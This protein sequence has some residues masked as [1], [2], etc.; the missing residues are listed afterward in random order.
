MN[1][2]PL[3]LR[4]LVDVVVLIAAFIMMDAPSAET[5]IQPYAGRGA[6][7]HASASAPM[8][9]PWPIALSASGAV[10]YG[11]ESSVYRYDPRTKSIS[12]VAGVGPDGPTIDGL[13][14]AK[15]QLGRASSLAVAPDGTLYIADYERNAIL[16]VDTHGIISVFAGTPGVAGDGGDNGP[17][18]MARFN[19]PVYIATDAAG[20]L[21]VADYFN[22][23][24]R[25]IQHGII[26]TVAGTEGSYPLAVTVDAHGSLYYVDDS[27]SAYGD[28]ILYRLPPGGAPT[29][30]TPGGLHTFGWLEGLTVDGAGDLYT[31]NW[32]PGANN[33][34]KI[35]STGTVSVIAGNAVSAFSPDG[36]VASSASLTEPTDIAATPDGVLYFTEG[37]S[38]RI[39]TITASGTLKTL[40]GSGNGDGGPALQAP[41][42]LLHGGLATDA[43]GNLYIGNEASVRAV[44][45][46]SQTISTYVGTSDYGDSGDGGAATSARLTR[47][48][49]IAFDA[50]GNLYIVDHYAHKV[51]KVAPNGA[52]STYAGNGGTPATIDAGNGGPATQ[53][54]LFRPYA[55]AADA[56]GNVYVGGACTPP[57]YCGYRVHPFAS[58]V[59]RIDAD[60]VISHFA[61]NGTEGYSGDGGPAS[62]A[63]LNRPT[64]FA[65]DRI[66]N[67]Y[68]CDSGNN[69]IRKVDVNGLIT[70][71][72]GNGGAGY[73]GDGGRALDATLN[74]PRD[75]AVDLAGNLYIADFGNNVV[76]RVSTLGLISTAAGA[77]SRGSDDHG[78][79][80]AESLNGPIA[81]AVDGAGNLYVQDL[82]DYRVS[83]VV[84][85]P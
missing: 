28:D 80:T 3:A 40:A 83:R 5:L 74:A 50:K 32:A 23:R 8:A 62:Q 36:T 42:W 57:M 13:A 7:L 81:V 76:R 27:W 46:S 61:G 64:G 37:Y 66:G 56:L 51:R 29:L 77:R 20:S 54:S 41:F 78:P 58:V 82:F 73:T 4:R 19:F 33:L 71:V 31:T 52:I 45:V 85:R 49:R 70:T 72:A 67:L 43:D 2:N 39:R 25:K 30:M 1:P 14:G 17:A 68:I 9:Q 18:T 60:G 15:A 24:V 84:R 79:A 12:L 26:S 53:A 48:D 34:I 47:V 44:S 69:R 55:I 59:R 38:G 16:R 21:Y 22:G 10:Y 35:S 75:V 65:A 11:V 6:L 63:A